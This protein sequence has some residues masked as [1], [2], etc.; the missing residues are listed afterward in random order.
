MKTRTIVSF[1]NPTFFDIN[2]NNVSLDK[3]EPSVRRGQKAVGAEEVSACP[4]C[5]RM[6]L[7]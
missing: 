5:R 4:S 1:P 6:S 7:W 3:A 2:I